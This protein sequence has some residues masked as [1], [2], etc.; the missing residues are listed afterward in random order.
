MFGII[1]GVFIFCW[2]LFFIMYVIVFFCS[3]C[4]L[5]LGVELGMI[6]FGYVN[7]VFNFVIYIVF[8][9]DF[10]KVFIYLVGKYIK[11]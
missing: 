8:N 7:L 4:N 1:V 3:F 6:F 5:I 9:V 2:L 11:C 10:R